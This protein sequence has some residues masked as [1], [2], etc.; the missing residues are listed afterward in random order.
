M[1]PVVLSEKENK[2]PFH[3]HLSSSWFCCIFW[4]LEVWLWIINKRNVRNH[5]VRQKWMLWK[6]AWSN[7]IGLRTNFNLRW[8][9]TVV[10]RI[11]STLCD[12]LAVI[13][14]SRADTA[15]VTLK[16]HRQVSAIGYCLIPIWL[17]CLIWWLVKGN[18]IFKHFK[19]S[20]K[21]GNFTSQNCI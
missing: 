18:N 7:L 12:F 11:D 16:R 10:K 9:T 21:Y 6:T 20:S 1:L 15:R 13:N 5:W 4:L 14:I 17:K 19:K 8:L 2:I 3:Y